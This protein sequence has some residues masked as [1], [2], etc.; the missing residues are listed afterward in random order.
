MIKK[1]ILSLLLCLPFITKADENMYL[2]DV[3]QYSW[4]DN[5]ELN[6]SGGVSAF[7]GSP[8]GCDDLFGRSRAAFQTS[9]GK[10]HTP[11]IGNRIVFQGFSWKNG[12]LRNQQY[13]HWHAD[14]LWNLMPETSAVKWSIVPFAGVGCI[15]N[16]DT[17]L[18]SFALNFGLMARYRLTNHWHITGELADAI[19]TK[20]ADGVGKAQSLGDTNLSFTVG[21]SFTFGRNCGWKKIK[22]ANAYEAENLRLD[23][24]ITNQNLRMER[25]ETENRL[26]SEMVLQLQKVF[27]I[28]GLLDK[29]ADLFKKNDL[30]PSKSYPSNNYS[31]LNSLRKRMR[32]KKQ[33]LLDS[34]NDQN[35]VLDTIGSN[36]DAESLPHKN[37]N[38]YV[39]GHSANNHNNSSNF[40]DPNSGDSLSDSLLTRYPGL[41]DMNR[42]W[43]ELENDS[44][45][46]NGCRHYFE[47]LSD[48]EITSLINEDGD[49]LGAPIFFFFQLNSDRL[50][51]GSQ[52]QNLKAIARVAKKYGLLID[53]IGAADSATGSVSRN[54][55]LG[56]QRANVIEKMFIQNGVNPDVIRKSSVGGINR[57]K[58][59]EANR[60]AIVKLMLP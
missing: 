50:V 6:V 57:Y 14:L 23:E 4:K 47:A 41:A 3:A 35:P 59:K 28:E 43:K 42:P 1:L 46:I 55:D 39:D 26:N 52:T 13:R 15:D 11:R 21:V 25:L 32:E 60:N 18:I 29:Y 20:N 34:V 17:K 9:I 45:F 24:F 2:S 48:K 5:W 30:N 12:E 53:I 31:G 58:P 37:G 8:I 38:Y 44:L 54:R 36:F 10:W 33:M 7:I 51:D 40:G 22:N 27:D 16:R 56:H 49:C 19:S